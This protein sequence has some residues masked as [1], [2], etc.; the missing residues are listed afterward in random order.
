MAVLH[1]HH[2]V[3]A[4]ASGLIGSA[5]VASLLTDGYQ[6]TRLV[7][8]VPSTT[9]GVAGNP[10]LRDIVW[11]PGRALSAEAV[12]ACSNAK[13]VICLN[14]VSIARLPWTPSY[15]RALHD[16]RIVPAHTLAEALSRVDGPA[17]L[18]VCASAAGFYGSAPG[19]TLTE[20]SPAGDTFLAGLCRDWENAAN[21]GEPHT[22]VA[23]LR[24]ASL[25]HP[26]ALLKPLIP[27][28][29]L[30]M[31][32]PLGSGRQIWPWIS[33]DDEVRAIRHII[34]H[35]LTGPF[36]LVAPARTSAND[37]IAAVAGHLHRPFWFPV[38]EPLLHLVLGS[39]AARSLVT[40]DA[41]IVPRRLE[42]SGFV[43]AQPTLEQALATRS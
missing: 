29:R 32:G 3:I 41:H 43:F 21:S 39:D 40:A 19:V 36:N 33:L 34:D 2:V 14:V 24:T 8:D 38:P 37:V 22:P 18:F 7:R 5:L 30:G 23:L 26:K 4:G 13:A 6:V 35:A 17:P 25:L 27:L 10:A 9:D 1:S 31:A 20:S 12:K 28:A 11:Q 42:E 15:R 16:S